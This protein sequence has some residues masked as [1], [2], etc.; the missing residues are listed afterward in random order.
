M[1]FP[2][3]IT[4]E[5]TAARTEAFSAQKYLLSED[6]AKWNDVRKLLSDKTTTVTMNNTQNEVLRAFDALNDVKPV[7]G[8]A[9]IGYNPEGNMVNIS[10]GGKVRLTKFKLS[11]RG[12][13]DPLEAYMEYR[14]AVGVNSD[15]LFIQ[16][17]FIFP[18]LG[19]N[20][21]AMGL[22]WHAGTAGWDYGLQGE[23]SLNRYE[24]D[25]GQFVS[26][27]VFIGLRFER[28]PTPTN[29][30]WMAIVPYFNL[31]NVDSKYNAFYPAQLNEKNLPLKIY[32]AGLNIA[33]GPQNAALFCNM[34]YLWM[35]QTSIKDSE[36]KSF[37]YTVGIRAILSKNIINLF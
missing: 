14:T 18:E 21:L 2:A 24:V 4:K 22:Y 1:F 5:E 3:I 19:K 12:K 33:I 27:S 37:V 17:T 9:G 23:V 30:N 28:L 31:I 35:D 16:K 34:K 13:I 32:A 36:L 15:T 7:N 29:T 10:V 20:N 6:K 8:F 25:S 11:R 26:Q